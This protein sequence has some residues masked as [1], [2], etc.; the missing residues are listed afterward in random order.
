MVSMAA[1][2]GVVKLVHRGRHVEI[3]KEPITASEVMAKNPRHFITRPDVF[4]YPWIVVKPESVLTPGRVYFVV[5]HRTIYDLTKASGHFNQPLSPSRRPSHY[6]RTRHRSSDPPPTK[7][8]NPSPT[9][10]CPGMTPKHLWK[11]RGLISCASVAVSP[12]EVPRC[13]SVR[14]PYKKR[15]SPVESCSEVVKSSE[16]RNSNREFKGQPLIDI[17]TEYRTYRA[18]EETSGSVDN[19]FMSAEE[20]ETVVVDGDSSQSISSAYHEQ[21]TAVLK[22]CLGKPDSVRKSLSLRVTFAL[23]NVDVWL[24][25]RAKKSSKWINI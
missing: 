4:E 12:M 22:S 18:N 13:R 15:Y 8:A 17:M 10:A 3:L 5:P 14:G 7:L 16:C 19:L 1:E 6:S 24:Q 20:T 25:R 11:S 21:P 2:E 9:V 23:P